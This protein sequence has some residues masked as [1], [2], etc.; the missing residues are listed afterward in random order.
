MQNY[1]IPSTATILKNWISEP[2]L[3]LKKHLNLGIPDF[4]IFCFIPYKKDVTET[5]FPL[6]MIIFACI[7]SIKTHGYEILF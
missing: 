1:F 3:S 4:R 2:A 5:H 7:K 6:G